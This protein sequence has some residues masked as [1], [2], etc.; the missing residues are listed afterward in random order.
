MKQKIM[1]TKIYWSQIILPQSLC[2]PCAT[3]SDEER[4]NGKPLIVWFLLEL[5]IAPFALRRTAHRKH[6]ALF[7]L[8]I[9]MFAMLKTGE[10]AASVFLLSLSG[11]HQLYTDQ[12][13][14]TFDACVC[15]QKTTFPQPNANRSRVPP[16]FARTTRPPDS[17]TISHPASSPG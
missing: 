17:R 4:A 6:Y 14:T 9:Q 15:I 7:I 13:H 1:C 3:R 5:C 10:C 11:A 8:F 2:I 12:K 16:L